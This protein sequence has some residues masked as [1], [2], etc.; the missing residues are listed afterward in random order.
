M[1]AQESI[2]TQR[3]G[4][5]FNLTAVLFGG[6]SKA[7]ML[8]FDICCKKITVSILSTVKNLHKIAGM[9]YNFNNNKKVIL[10]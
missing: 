5:I 1:T 4:V 10:S 6:Y 3:A 9:I 2:N 7:L 8:R